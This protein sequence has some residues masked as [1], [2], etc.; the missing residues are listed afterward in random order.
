VTPGSLPE[1]EKVEI[2][3]R[4]KRGLGRVTQPPFVGSSPK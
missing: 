2:E 4:G 3:V 1:G